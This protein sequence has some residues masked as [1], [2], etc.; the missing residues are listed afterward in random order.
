M[1]TLEDVT[2]KRVEPSSAAAAAAAELVQPHTV[3]DDL[4]W[5]AVAFVRRHR[6]VT[7]PLLPACRVR[8]RDSA[9]AIVCAS[10]RQAHVPTRE[11]ILFA[12]IRFL[13]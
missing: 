4:D 12:V 3:V 8:Q 5:V 11:R 7:R 10:E 1:T 13:H 9:G 6:G 2:K